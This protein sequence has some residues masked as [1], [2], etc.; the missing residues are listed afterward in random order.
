[1]RLGGLQ[2]ALAF[3]TVLPLPRAWRERELEGSLPWFPLAGLAVG[4]LSAAAWALAG[5]L[6]G[7]PLLAALGAVLTGTLATG[8]L[9]LDGLADTCDAAFSWRSRERKLEIMRDSR[10]GTMGALGLF[11]GL[12]TRVAA[13]LALGPLAGAAA[14]LAPVWGRWAAVYGLIRFPPARPDGLGRSLQATARPRDLVRAT[15]AA[16]LAGGLLWPP[17]G[18]L[19][20]LPAWLAAHLWAS[21][22]CADLGGLTGDGCGSLSEAAE[23]SFL[24]ALAAGFH[25]GWL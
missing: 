20:G 5:G 24:L 8:A 6:W 13:L 4:A 10:I 18:A 23:L 16:L 14:L 2:A 21:A 1:M 19:A 17:W 11:F 3:L 22:L 7:S 9:H 25:H 15:F 12:G